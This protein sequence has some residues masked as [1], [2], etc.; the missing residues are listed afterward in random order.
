MLVRDY[1]QQADC[2]GQHGVSDFNAFVFV[3]VTVIAK[4]LADRA[5]ADPGFAEVFLTGRPEPVRM[6]VL[7]IRFVAQ[8]LN[9][10]VNVR[11]CC[12]PAC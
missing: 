6:R 3:S 7:D 5:N 12:A 8:L 11:G 1:R 2:L 10:G 4:Q 9:S